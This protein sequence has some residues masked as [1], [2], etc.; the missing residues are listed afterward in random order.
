MGK[1]IKRIALCLGVGAACV[2]TGG[3]AAPA[4]GAAVGGIMGLSGAAATS[5]GLAAIGGGALAAGGLGMAGGTAI[6]E[7]VAGGAGLVGTKIALSSKDAFKAKKENAQLREELK[8]NNVDLKTKQKVI[9]NLTARIMEL[10]KK[11]EEEESKNDK[12]DE[13]IQSLKSQIEEIKKTLLVAQAA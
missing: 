4:I 9:V 6:I 5:A 3:L 10:E 7:A 12:N 11:L 13:A 2:L 1:K 8:K